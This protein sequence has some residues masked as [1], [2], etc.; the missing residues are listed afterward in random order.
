M[1]GD[2]FLYSRFLGLGTWFRRVEGL[3]QSGANLSVAWIVIPIHRL[4]SISQVVPPDVLW[5]RE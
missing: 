2:R 5:R 3:V 4:A 1:S